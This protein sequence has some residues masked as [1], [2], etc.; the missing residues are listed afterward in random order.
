MSIKRPH[1]KRVA[2]N[3]IGG[4][5]M[6]HPK[7]ETILAELHQT[8]NE[9]YKANWKLDVCVTTNG[10]IG[11]NTIERCVN[12]IDTWSISYHTEAL[13]KQK[14]LTLANIRKLHSLNKRLE[15]RVM[16]PSDNT[17]FSEASSV[18]T[19]LVSEGVN[20]LIKPITGSTYQSEKTEYLKIFWKGKD[21]DDIKE[22][23]TDKGIACCSDRLL[24]LNS[25]TKE[26]TNFIP[27]NNFEDW[28][29]GLNLS[30]LFVDHNSRVYHNNSCHVS[31]NTS[32]EDP[33]GTSDNYEQILTTLREHIANKSIPVVV[34]PKNLC[35]SCGMCAPKAKTKEEFVK[36]MSMH[37]SDV[38]LLDFEAHQPN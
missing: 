29:C 15:V 14:E 26:R 7:I 37:L 18:H 13:E 36:I 22:Y 33:I 16:A 24:I 35:T 20:A 1:E 30:F 19:T 21:V 2:L 10:A 9:K 25:N 27:M 6:L 11:T 12:Y 31:Y 32:K 28:Y 38:T 4:E 8:Y 3:L 17:K 23:S 5:P 34:C